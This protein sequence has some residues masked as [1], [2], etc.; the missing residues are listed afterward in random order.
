MLMV[1]VPVVFW[2][3]A[4]AMAS[5][6]MAVEVGAFGLTGWAV[7]VCWLAAS[8]LMVDSTDDGRAGRSFSDR[9]RQS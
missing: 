7:A 8:L 2:T 3:S 5:R 6:A 4:V 9:G 1:G